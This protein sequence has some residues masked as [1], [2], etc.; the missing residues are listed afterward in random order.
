M[1]AALGRSALPPAVSAPSARPQ[2]RCRGPAPMTGLSIGRTVSLPV[3]AGRAHV[4]GTADY[5]CWRRSAK[6]VA[7]LAL[8]AGSVSMSHWKSSL[9]NLRS[10][11]GSAHLMVARRA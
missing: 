1:A 5:R 10:R 9:V 8:T 7:S 6:V 3:R 11:P 4:S 2:Q